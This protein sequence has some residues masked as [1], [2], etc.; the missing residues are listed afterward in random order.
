MSE[1]VTDCP[2]C[3]AKS[4]TFDVFYDI[5]IERHRNWQVWYEA[6]CV[7]RA[8]HH[9]TVFILSQK[10]HNAA[11]YLD[12]NS[13]SG[14]KGTV[15]DYV[16]VENHLSLK[17]ESSTKPPEHLPDKILAVFE[18]GATC[19]AVDCY[20]AS[21]TMFRL[22]IDLATKPM[23]P[24]KD[25]N[26]LNKQIRRN[27]GSRLPWLFDKEV[28]P[29]SL[30]DLSSCIKD[31]GNDGAHEGTLDK[32]DVED[33]LDFTFELLERIFTEPERLRIAKERRTKRR[34]KPNT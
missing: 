34:E 32:E 7:C 16:V 12:K 4:I 14:I 21:A 2:R 22:C 10:N 5:P 23:L 9:S 13:V 30:R 15:N 24:E 6:F 19:L 26:G 33:I 27:L 29:K 1:L 28:L 31:D 25:E 18:E 8:C 20:N 17:D 3:K 11:E